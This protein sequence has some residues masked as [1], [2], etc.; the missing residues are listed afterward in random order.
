MPMK[1][2]AAHYDGE[3]VLFDEE[4][5]IRPQTKLLVTILDDSDPERES[6]LE[7]ASTSFADFY[8]DDEVEYTADD[9]KR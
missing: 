5:E 2:I 7:V 6:F 1:S 4:V 8:D 9:L 3:R